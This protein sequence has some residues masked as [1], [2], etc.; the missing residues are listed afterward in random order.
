[1]S[2]RPRARNMRRPAPSIFGWAIG[3][4]RAFPISMHPATASLFW[5][6]VSP[7]GQAP[8]LAL[9]PGAGSRHIVVAIEAAHRLPTSFLEGASQRALRGLVPRA[10]A[11]ID[12]HRR[13]PGGEITLLAPR[14]AEHRA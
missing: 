12:R 1:M 10:L 8:A 14:D 6:S 3:R 9:E 5:P 4:P 2:I 13:Q 11:G 7:I